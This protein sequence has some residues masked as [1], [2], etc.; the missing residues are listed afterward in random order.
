MPNSDNTWGTYNK[1]TKILSQIDDGSTTSTTFNNVTEAKE[2]F[3]KTAALTVFDE[4]CTTLQ[5]ALAN[6]D[7]GDA[8]RLKMTYDF[9]TKGAGVTT[10]N[11]WGPLFNSR[12]QTLI[13]SDG[14][15]NNPHS[16]ATSTDHLF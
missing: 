4:C 12:M 7:N 15:C 14:W 1:Q 2:F 6:D 10:A 3:Y 13:S 9:G 8:T 5:W 11:D 16:T